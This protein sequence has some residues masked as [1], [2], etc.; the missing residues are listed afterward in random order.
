MAVRE[1]NKKN[2]VAAAWLAQSMLA[3][4][5]ESLCSR[6]ATEGI[7]GTDFAAALFPA[8]SAAAPTRQAEGPN[9]QSKAAM[10]FGAGMAAL[11]MRRE[12]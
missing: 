7:C 8:L 5:S 6:I 4:A 9:L 2:C 11:A 10:I 1:Q 3:D 12:S